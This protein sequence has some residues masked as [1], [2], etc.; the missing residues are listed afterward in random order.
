MAL[1]GL[2][3]KLK[4]LL[5][6]GRA[7]DELFEELEDLLIE[8]DL[9][10]ACAAGLAA[11]LRALAKKEGLDSRE[12]LLTALRSRLESMVLAA[13]LE[14]APD[15]LNIVLVLGVN[16]VGKT[17]TI[18]KLAAYYRQV[19]GFERSVF[20][21]GDTFRAGAIDQLRLHAER[22]GMR[23]VA[24]A[25]GSDP[26]AVIFDALDSARARGEKLV[27]ADTAG[28]M[29]NKANLVRELQ[30]IDKIIQ[31]KRGGARYRKLLVMDA[32]TGQNGLRQ[33]E[34]FHEAIKLDS[35]ILSKYDSTAK[36]G[37]VV[38]V[39]RELGL[40]ISFV[41]CGEKLTDLKPFSRTEFI[42]GFF[43]QE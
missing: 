12:G 1:F 36:G 34:V 9:G 33:A 19:A 22:L 29:H 43:D 18:A 2:G 37:V 38:A 10:A 24:Q 6:L 32:T 21:A 39:S 3:K 4:A 30:K 8:A 15:E 26:A 28:R 20:A 31:T 25:E 27:F 42:R 16:G 7:G 17:T 41:G 35:V 13:P 23:L 11:E 40:P 14:L 5:G